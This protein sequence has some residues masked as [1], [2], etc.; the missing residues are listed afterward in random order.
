MNAWSNIKICSPDPEIEKID[1]KENVLGEIPAQVKQIRELIRRFEVCHFKSM[2]HFK[3]IKD[4]IL[5]LQPTIIPDHIGS[6]HI[7]KGESAWKND[8]TGRSFLGQQYL[9]V[10]KN[11]LGEDIRNQCS[12]IVETKL[13]RQVT[14][15]LKTKT[16]DNERLVRLLIARL[17]WDWESYD[18][19]Q[20]GGELEQLEN[21]IGRMDICH[22]A[23]PKNLD[24]VLQGIGNLE[25]VIQFEG[26]GTYNPDIKTYFGE[27]LTKLCGWLKINKSKNKEKDS[28]TKAWLIACL[29]KTLKEQLRFDMAIAL[30]L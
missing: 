17:T 12:E 30:N 15:W 3:N 8:K 6:N 26:C 7:H 16:P 9:L 5:N 18:E 27:E 1:S 11:W 10:L 22:Y 24:C 25:S 29:V 28:S 2:Q 14:N 21:Q 23:F 20:K 19:L 4:S 13:N